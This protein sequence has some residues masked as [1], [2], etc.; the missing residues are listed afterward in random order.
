MSTST[1]EKRLVLDWTKIQDVFPVESHLAQSHQALVAAKKSLLDGSGKGSD[2]L[3]WV[4]YPVDEAPKMLDS[5]KSVI[6]AVCSHSDA[7]VVIGIGGSYLGARAISQ[8]LTHAYSHLNPSEFSR[9]PLLFW[10]GNHMASDELAELLDALDIYTP[11]LVV[12]SK[13]GGTTEPAMAFRILKSYMEDRFGSAEARERIFA[14][15]DPEDGILLKLAKTEG[16]PH[17]PIPKN[18]GG[19]YSVFTPVGLLPLAIAGVD[20]NA[21]VAGAQ[22]AFEDASSEKNNSFETNVALCYAGLRNVLYK[23]N[24]K[25][26]ALCTWSP[27][28]SMIAEWWK[29]LFGESD[30]KGNT[31]LFPAS[32]NFTS[33]L[34]SLG[35]YFQEGER[36]MFA[37]HIRVMDEHSITKGCVKRRVRIP[38]AG[39]ND[40]F[41]F[42]NDRELFSVQSEAQQGTFL[43][44][45]DGKL[46]TM[47][48]EMPELNAWWLGYWLYTNMFACAVAGYARGINPFDQ[49]GVEAYKTNMFALLGKPGHTDKGTE[50]RARIERGQRLRSL[51]LSTR[52]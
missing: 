6:D 2:F 49:S 7:V 13:S 34:H 30:A 15:T 4:R 29:Q 35:Q 50:L 39:L 31:G 3:G 24:F 28:L 10:A 51:G 42:L 8:A 12:I 9:R 27:K 48:W 17:F 47:V 44:H 38:G 46:P 43:A 16:Y 33:D 1:S 14:V 20:V 21:L 19:R 45:A 52:S 40:G 22:Q 32:A 18:V 36:H 5:M 26:E 41:Q 25:I 23:N 11:S 37:T